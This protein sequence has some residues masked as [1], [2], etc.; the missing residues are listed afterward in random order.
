MRN[1]VRT[2]AGSHPHPTPPPSRGREW[3]GGGPTLFHIRTVARRWIVVAAFLLGLAAVAHAAEAPRFQVDA[4]WPKPL[5]NNWL[6]GQ[7]AGV[8]IDKD[9]HIWI[10]QRPRTLTNDE[11]G[12]SL[13]PP[14]SSCCVPA[15]PV[16]EF[17]QAGHVIKA[18]GGPGPGY[19]WPDNEH[20]I[21]VDDG[22]NV[23]LG[24][25]GAKDG[26]VLKFTNDGKF[27]M[28]IGHSGPSL[29]SN[30]PGQLGRPADIAIDQAANEVYIADGYANRRVIVFDA[31]SGAYKRHW[32]AYGKPPVQEKL[33]MPVPAPGEPSDYD[34]KAPPSAQFGNPVHCVKL[35]R[36]GLVYVCDRIN[37]RI[38]VFKKDGS[39]VREWFYD[40]ATLGNGAV[41]DLALWPDRDQSYLI[42]AD[43]ENNLV[44]IIR[45]R[46]GAVVGSFGRSGRQAGQF[47]WVHNI[48]VDS[49]GNVYTTE[50]D[51]AK[52]V[53]RFKPVNG[54]PQR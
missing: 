39:F 23:W 29:G 52:R 50:V 34:A 12:A 5:P 48:A 54:A 4:S 46:D 11:K 44:R 32:G 42:N 15:P 43:G 21:R 36:D 41:W 1:L 51:N 38:Q 20:G 7:V 2:E 49:R 10:I 53:Q 13:T 45:R 31:T 17:D 47:H 37:D 3:E 25:N 24:G 22:G 6:L 18:W 28:Q 8:A 16:I 14:R 40:K 35:A 26:M 27:L 9:D 30:D 19:E 33:P